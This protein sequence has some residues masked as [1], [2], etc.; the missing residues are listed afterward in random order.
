MRA[1]LQSVQLGLGGLCVV[2]TIAFAYLCTAPL[3]AFDP[4]AMQLAARKPPSEI[5]PFM[6]PP[7]AAFAAIDA[8]PMFNPAR[9]PITPSALPGNASSGPPPAPDITLIGVILDGKTQLAMVKGQ[10]APFA[11][12]VGVGESIGGWQVAEISPDHVSLRAGVYEHT[13]RMDDKRQALPSL[14]VT[15]QPF[16]AAQPVQ[17]APLQGMTTPYQPTTRRIGSPQNQDGT[18]SVDQ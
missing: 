7:Q 8:R 13:L 6:A 5:T 14:P 9:R 4:P 18:N 15:S 3:P 17:R 1:M 2:L 10:G 12:S 11:T 16:G